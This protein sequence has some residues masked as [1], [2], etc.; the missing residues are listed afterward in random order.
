MIKILIVD[1]HTAI[2]DSF[3]HALEACDDMEVLDDIADASL[4]L[5]F[6]RSL[7]P[8]VVL[9]DVCT[10]GGASGLKAAQQLKAQMPHIKVIV[11]TGFDEITYMPRAKESGADAFVEKSM[12]LPFFIQVIRDVAS[13]GSYFPKR[14]SI[15]VQRGESPLTE[16]EIQVLK[17]VCQG[18]SR[19]QIAQEMCISE[20]TV[21]RHIQNITGKMG[22]E[23]TSELVAHVVL[24]GWLNPK[25]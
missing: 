18:L 15:P 6:C 4:A 8:D 25:Y 11:M 13:G 5:I 3:R 21:Y 20:N 24:N 10:A 12:S 16:R 14:K 7:S 22:F 9:M 1:D 17:M 23:R 19:V 2:R